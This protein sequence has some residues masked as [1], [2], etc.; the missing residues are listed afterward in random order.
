MNI[1]HCKKPISDEGRAKYNFNGDLLIYQN[2][3]AMHELISYADELL[4]GSLNRVEPA[5]AQHHFSPDEFLQR[6]MKAQTHFRKSQTAKGY[7]FK[8]LEQ[9]GVDLNSTYYDHFPMRIVPTDKAYDG[10]HCGVISHHRDTWGSNIHSQINWWAPLYELEEE[11]TIGLYPDYWQNPIANN[12]DTW[13]FEDFLKQRV[14]TGHEH[15]GSYASAP[16]LLETVD[17]SGVVKVMLEPGDIVS[18]ASA[19]LHASV[20]NTTKSTR[21]SVEMRSINKDDLVNNRAAPNVD[22]AA[23]TPMYQWFRNILS[24]EKLSPE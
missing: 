14:D 24:K 18:F 17:E 12:T 16:S 22:N 4:R 20:P 15:A 21:F 6:T 1:I 23:T 2:V 8:A 10:A 11:R 3:P 9:C 5:E 19:H 7:F 13:C